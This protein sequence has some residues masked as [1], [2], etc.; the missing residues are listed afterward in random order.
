MSRIPSNSRASFGGATVLAAL[1]LALLMLPGTLAAEDVDRSFPFELDTWYDLNVEADG[2][3][4]HRVRVEKVDSNIKSR[5]FRPGIKD[6]PMIQDVQIQVEYSNDSRRDVEA[7]LE[8]F[9]VDSRGRRID[10][11]EGEED[12]D[13]GER[14]EQMT[15]LRSTL[16]Y[17]LDV[18][19]KLDVK[20]RF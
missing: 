20:I 6:D 3:T 19:E 16:T 8:I 9:W 7:D 12:M 15:A 2:I 5:V 18:A 4:L 14:Y 10:G 17:G 13:E 1:A 11:Y